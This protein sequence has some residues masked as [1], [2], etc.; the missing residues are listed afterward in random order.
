MYRTCLR[1][2]STRFSPLAVVSCVLLAGVLTVFSCKKDE[3]LDFG[4]IQ[5][6][7]VSGIDSLGATFHAKISD[8]GNKHIT[9]YGFVWDTQPRPTVESS[10]KFII[11]AVPATG[12][13]D[14]RISTTFDEQ[15]RYY[16][17]AFIQNESFI[18]YGKEVTFISLGSAAPSITEFYPAT[19]N[20][21]DTVFI[22]GANFSYKP[23]NNIVHFGEYAAPVLAASQDTLAVLVPNELD[24]HASSI[25]VAIMGNAATSSQDFQLIAP[26]ISDFE[27]KMGTFGSR[28]TI[29]GSNFRANPGSLTVHIG[30]IQATITDH[31][32]GSF[33]IACTP[34]KAPSTFR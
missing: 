27:A 16:V 28:V 22:V 1:L 6:G 4:L 10:E 7:D 9:A 11:K 12:V 3:A 25:R 21:N 14:Q 19:A 18:T 8:L 32:N 5:T 29:T 15:V 26:V 33:P 2:S 24:E 20:L 17:R 23:S 30:G 13:L 31:Q 34:G